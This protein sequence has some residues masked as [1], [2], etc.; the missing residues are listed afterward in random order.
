MLYSMIMSFSCMLNLV[1]IDLH[2]SNRG[3]A[4]VQAVKLNSKYCNKSS[5]ALDDSLPITPPGVPTTAGIH[6]LN[7]LWWP[8]HALPH[9][10]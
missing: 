9:P 5:L 4:R 8:Q 10:L 7:P 1:K 2:H 3:T 6:Y